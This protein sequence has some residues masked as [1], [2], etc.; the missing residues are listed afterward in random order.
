MARKEYNLIQLLWMC[1]VMRLD[2]ALKALPVCSGAGWEG[3][4]GLRG[5]QAER[6][7]GCLTTVRSGISN[8]A[9]LGLT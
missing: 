3:C 9:D 4:I 8:E 6:G 1:L 5:D 2:I 7:H